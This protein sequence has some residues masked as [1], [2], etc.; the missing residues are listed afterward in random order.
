MILVYWVEDQGPNAEHFKAGDVIGFVPDTHQFSPLELQFPSWRMMKVPL[1]QTECE[2]LVSQP[3]RSENAPKG[4]TQPL[5]AYRFNITQLKTF[6]SASVTDDK[7]RQPILDATALVTQV[8]AVAEQ[9]PAAEVA[10]AIPAP[11]VDE[12]PVVEVKG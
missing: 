7:R 1:T 8:R 11:P 12:K 10:P 4:S 3:T 2:A 6:A 9:K 5:R